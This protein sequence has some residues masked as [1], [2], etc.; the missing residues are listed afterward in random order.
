ML[1]YFSF[2]HPFNL[3]QLMEL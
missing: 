2:Y 1:V 3:F